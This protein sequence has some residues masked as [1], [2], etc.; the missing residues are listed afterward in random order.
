ML[1]SIH[2]QPQ[3]FKNIKSPEREKTY[4]GAKTV[5]TLSKLYRH[6]LSLL[7]D[8]YQLS[9]AYGYWNAGVADREA[10]F[11]LFYRRNP[12]GG[13]H[14]VCAGL[15]EVIDYLENYRFEHDDIAYLNSLRGNNET[16]LFSKEFLEELRE[17]RFSCD[18]DALPEGTA[19]FAHEPMIRVR[20]PL[21]QA[22]LIETPLVNIVNFQT[23]I[24]TKAARVTHAA[25]ED[26]V[27]EFGLRRAQGIDGGVS[28]SRAAY[29]GG[30]A[31]TSNLLAG[32]L[33]GIPV[34]GTHAHSWVMVFEDELEAFSAYAKAMPN[35]CVFLVDTYDTVEGVRHAIE[36]GHRLREQGYEM[37][38]V[39][40]DS[41]DL[42]W[43]SIEARKELDEAGFPN[44]MVLASNDL[45][46]R[47]IESLKTQGAAI[48]VW[49]VGTKLV[50][51]HE[52][53]ALGAVYKL[54]SLRNE[55]GEWEDR[56]KLSEQAI[57]TSTPGILNA[58]RYRDQS[59]FIGDVIYDE[60][61]GCPEP[62]VIVDPT[63]ATRRKSFTK[64]IEYED[65]LHPIFRQ[66]RLV[67]D[68]PGLDAIRM[69]VK[70]QL[71]ALHEGVKRFQ[72]PHGYPVG[73]ELGLFERKR[74]L[75]LSSRGFGSG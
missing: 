49:G 23:L 52:Q 35:N 11:H 6:S 62:C 51:G 47:V 21:M 10:V 54:A 72:N 16:R 13:G 12:F 33:H 27:L 60:K 43:L 50:T 67:Y 28:A 59:G 20:G 15:D 5:N 36:I 53:A 46:E 48:N 29:L 26:P 74:E 4:N 8:L 38:G 70:E 25:K 22:Q 75:I 71:G 18:V 65:M 73:L 40:L 57:K 3:S 44:A 37:N 69:R 24:A 9:M 55:K 17:M 41:G 34:R 31:A 61:S 56:I 7:T 66:G 63:D 2:L 32:K 64:S 58:R 42:A 30:C 68:R 14:A 45:D 39:R 1:R 19:V